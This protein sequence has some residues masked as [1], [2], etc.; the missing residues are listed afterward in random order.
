[1]TKFLWSSIEGTY[2]FLNSDMAIMQEGDTPAAIR[3]G[4]GSDQHGHCA[5]EFNKMFRP[6]FRSDDLHNSVVG[7][8]GIG[9]DSEIGLAQFKTSHTPMIFELIEMEKETRL[10]AFEKEAELDVRS[11]SLLMTQPGPMEIRWDYNGFMMRARNDDQCRQFLRDLHSA[12]ENG[13]VYYVEEGKMRNASYYSGPSMMIASRVSDEF[14]RD[15]LEQD[16]DVMKRG[17]AL[18]KTGIVDNLR[19]AGKQVFAITPQ[20][21]PKNS[22]TEHPVVVWVNPMDQD[23]NAAGIYTIE[24]LEDWATSDKDLGALDEGY[25]AARF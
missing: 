14:K 20:W 25:I 17:E 2:G 11:S 23:R 22:D 9:R 16:I 24:D 3:F 12:L 13:D 7:E 15:W 10:L 19:K 21:T 5:Y 18:R 6:H 8:H 4:S 1:M